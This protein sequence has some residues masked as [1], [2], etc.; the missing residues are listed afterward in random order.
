MGL[1]GS[2]PSHQLGP[3]LR[4]HARSV[5]TPADAAQIALFAPYCGGVHQEAA[6]MRVLPLFAEGE[7][8]GHRPLAGGALRPFV[9]RWSVVG[10]PLSLCSCHV[11]IAEGPALVYRFEL[12]A[13]QLM[14]WLMQVDPDAVRVDLPDGFWQWLLLEHDP[15]EAPHPGPLH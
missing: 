8:R 9:L 7:L 2:G 10:A 3:S 4:K 5:S 11:E 12:P 13:H 15:S 1:W 14:T 6:L